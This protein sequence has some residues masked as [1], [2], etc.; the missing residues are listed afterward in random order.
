MLSNGEIT[1]QNHVCKI[2]GAF[3]FNYMMKKKKTKKNTFLSQQV[4]KLPKLSR[5]TQ[6]FERDVPEIRNNF[7]FFF[8]LDIIRIFL[9]YMYFLSTTDI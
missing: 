8:N 9:E 6:K 4:I 7:L 1:R 5:S 2:I 3:V